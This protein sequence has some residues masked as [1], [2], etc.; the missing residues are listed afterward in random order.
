LKETNSAIA[1]PVLTEDLKPHLYQIVIVEP[2]NG[3]G[4]FYGV[5]YYGG[6]CRLGL[7]P[8]SGQIQNEPALLDMEGIENL[9]AVALVVVDFGVRK[10]I[11]RSL[12]CQ[13]GVGGLWMKVIDTTATRHPA[14]RVSAD[15]S[16]DNL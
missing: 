14:R 2:Q 5:K 11:I 6:Q 8:Q 16:I 7:N 12:V 1:V 13:L 10:P 15:A 3:Y 4:R 9:A